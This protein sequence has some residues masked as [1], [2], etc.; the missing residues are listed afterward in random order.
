MYI[1]ARNEKFLL[2]DTKQVTYIISGVNEDHIKEKIFDAI[3][4]HT[5]KIEIVPSKEKVI[6]TYYENIISPSFMDYK[7]NLKG[8]VFKR[9][10]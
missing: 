7:F 3:G 10:S 8:L 5:I 2:K 9:E 6:V 4:F 1:D